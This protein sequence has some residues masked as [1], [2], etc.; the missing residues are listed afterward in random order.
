[1]QNEAMDEFVEQVRARSDLLAVVS[2]YVRLRRRGGRYWG[3]CPFHQEKTPSF[4]VMPDKGFFYCFG[5]HA[6]GNVFKFLSLVENVSYFDAIKIQAERLGIPLPERKLSPEEQE[7]REKRKALKRVN[8]MARDFFHNCLTMTRY[9]EAGRAYLAGRGISADTIEEFSLGFAPD[10]WDKLSVAF[11]KRDVGRGLLLE[12]GLSIENRD[13]DGIHDRFRG[14]VIIPIADEQG[15]VVAFGG[16]VIGSGMPKYLNTPETMVFNKRRLLFGLDRAKRSIQ[17]E[18]YAIVTE[19][20]MDAISVASAGVRNVVASLGTAFTAE[21]AK[22]LLRYARKIYFCYDSDAAGQSATLRALPIVRGAGAEVYVVV[23]PEGK[24]PDE[25]IRNRG[26]DAFRSLVE[27]A[28]P[29]VEYRMQYV[30]THM[31]YDSLEGKVHAL[32]ALLPVLAGIRDTAELGEYRK[33]IAQALMLDEGVI[34]DELRS[35]SRGAYPASTDEIDRR[36]PIRRAARKRDGATLQAGRIVLQALWQDSSL[37]AHVRGMLPEG[38][39][40]PV[41]QEILLYLENCTKKGKS[42]D[43]VD[44]SGDLGEE[45]A[46]ELSRALAEAAGVEGVAAVYADALRVLRREYLNSL[47]ARHR[48]KTEAH[49][50]AGEMESYREE[51]ETLGRI[52]REMD[53]L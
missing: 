25:F 19:G 47:Y 5:C 21:H 34:T 41:Q 53:E 9:G 42:V 2:R 51:L 40:D 38:F 36:A 43:D 8:E 14:R 48:Q 44:A 26:R 35:F 27:R 16:R 30:L 13:G 18:G 52:K 39:I 22:L 32:H 1:M 33:R 37:L 6:G 31:R 29:L 10:A 24:D 7:R 17:Q 50:S 49:L 12:A 3:C 11:Q 28:L 46:E 4:S 15:R 45:A 23:V 20:Y